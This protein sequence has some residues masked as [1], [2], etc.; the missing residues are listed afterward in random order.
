M[1][2]LQRRVREHAWAAPG[3]PGVQAPPLAPFGAVRDDT[4]ST[5]LV[6]YLRDGPLLRALVVADGSAQVRTLGEYAVAAEAV[7][8]L[9]ADL[10]TQAGRVLSGRLTAALAT[11]TRQD[12]AALASVVLTPLLA[13]IGERD[14]VVVPTGVLTTVPWAVLPGCAGLPVTVAPSA[15]AWHAARHRPGVTGRAA[16]LLVAGPGIARGDAEVAA[17]A[18]LRPGALVLTGASATPAAT[19]AGLGSAAIAHLAAHGQHQAENALFATLELAGGPLLGYDLPL[20]AQVPSMVVLSACDLGLTDVRPGDETLG[21][22]TALLAA[23][24]RTVV[25][26]VARVADDAAM[27]AMVR[28]HRAIMAGG[29]AAPALATALAREPP[30]GF[31]CFGAC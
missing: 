23:G 2:S 25:A 31:V 15:T 27:R 19:L 28:Y 4:G 10:D 26:S 3:Q 12:A 18:A 1:E 9:R 29:A 5:G 24:A 22:V 13:G 14:M 8:R 21:M 20:V 16:A 11:A 17:I 7:L 6:V 30:T